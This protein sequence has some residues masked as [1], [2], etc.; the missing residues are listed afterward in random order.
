MAARSKAWVCG[1]SPAGIAGS[2]AAG[3]WMFVCCECC[4]LSGRGEYD[5]PIP[6]PEESYR[7]CLCVC[8]CLF[9]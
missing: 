7:V 2:N 3:A 5:G 8:V 9:V 1:R 6:R 4:V